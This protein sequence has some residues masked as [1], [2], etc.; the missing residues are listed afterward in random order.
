MAMVESVA[1][2]VYDELIGSSKVPLITKM[3]NLPKQVVKNIKT[4][5]TFSNK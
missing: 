2:V 5:N 3:L 4:R 1:G